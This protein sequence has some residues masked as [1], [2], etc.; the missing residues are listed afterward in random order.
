MRRVSAL[1]VFTLAL[2][3]GPA[4]AEDVIVLANGWGAQQE[5]AVANAGGTIAWKHGPTGLG[6]VRSPEAGLYEKLVASGAFRSA[7]RDVL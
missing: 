3:A 1:L 5:A 6:L 7:A 2:T 4:M